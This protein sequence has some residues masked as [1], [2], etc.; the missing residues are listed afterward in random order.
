MPRSTALAALFLLAVA[1]CAHGGPPASV[2]DRELD[3][4]AALYAGTY[5]SPVDEGARPDSATFY[6]IVPVD[7]PSGARHALYAE[8]RRGDASGA[9]TR[10][11]LFLFDETP[12]RAAN[13]LIAHSFTAP[14]AAEAL[15]GDRTLVARGALAH[16]RS[17]EPAGCDMT[18]RRDGDRFV[19]RIEAADCAITGR[20]GD[21]L[22]IESE[23][24]VTR[25]AIE[26]IERGY[27]P[28]GAL[29]FGNPEGRRY[30]WP[31]VQPTRP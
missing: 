23:T 17:L 28:D 1:G 24:V 30:V 6:R 22:K 26:Q 14:K 7:P 25:A 20:R 10:Q 5:L 31:R 8:M 19:G 29:R 16:A 11:R 2:L 4:I 3:A 13:R 15:I 21:P 12:G 9:I 27:G 18:F